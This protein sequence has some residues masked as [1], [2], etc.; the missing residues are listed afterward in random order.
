M[1]TEVE[2]Y[3]GF[4]VKPILP[5][6]GAEAAGVPFDQVPLPQET[7]DARIELSNKHAVLIFRD[8]GLDDARHVKF[9]Q[10]LGELEFGGPDQPDRFSSRYL[11][12]AGNM[13]LDGTIVKEGTRRWQYNEGNAVPHTDS[14]F[15]QHRSKYS[16][17][18]AHLVPAVGGNTDFFN[19]RQAYADLPEEKKEMLRELVIEH[20]L[21]HSRKIA[22]PEES[23]TVT[24]HEM[25]AKQ[26]AYH[27]FVHTAPNGNETLFIA[28]HAKR[29]V[30]PQVWDLEKSQRYMFSAKWNG[31]GDMVWWDNRTSMHRAA[32]FSDQT[33]KRDMRRT[34]VFDDGP[35]ALGAMR[36]MLDMPA[37]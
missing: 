30:G 21:W 10:Q 36:P 25:A 32:P 7:I 2:H 27:K 23:Q 33:E 3:K 4:T 24:A 12:D 20:D 13:N 16:L 5:G 6:F 1:S 37:A 29:V 15:N 22:A 34:T 11:F 35:H 14:S 28:A 26:P 9:S 18:L 17:L 31:P 8:T 19:V